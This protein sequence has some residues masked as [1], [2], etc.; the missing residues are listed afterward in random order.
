[1]SD[2]RP[3]FRITLSDTP[4]A[5]PDTHVL[6]RQRMGWIVLAGALLALLA[7][8]DYR[9]MA[10]DQARQAWFGEM[11]EWYSPDAPYPTANARRLQPVLQRASGD[12]RL[13]SGA[14][15]A[16]ALTEP[17]ESGSLPRQK[18][19]ER[20]DPTRLRDPRIEHL[21]RLR[22][23]W[24]DDP[25]LLA[26]TLR[27]YSQNHIRI[28]RD[29]LPA[30]NEHQPTRLAVPAVAR[31]VEQ[32]AA[33]GKRLDPENAFFPLLLAAA[34]FSA[35]E[36]EAGL[37]AFHEASRCPAWRNYG[38]EEG[39]AA[40]DLLRRG[41]GQIGLWGD[42]T[43]LA[44]VLLPEL[45]QIRRAAMMVTWHAE[46]ARV[47]GDFVR[48]H[49]LRADVIRAGV[50]MRWTG[51]TMIARLVGEAMVRIALPHSEPSIPPAAAHSEERSRN[52]RMMA[53]YDRYL[54]RVRRE[55]PGEVVQVA[56][57]LRM[58]RDQSA[59][60]EAEVGVAGW[61]SVLDPAR[62]REL[63]GLTLLLNLGVALL[64]WPAAALAAFVL[65]RFEPKERD[66]D[67]SFWRSLPSPARVAIL[68]M[69]GLL[70][71]LP[72][73]IDP[74]LPPLTTLTVEVL[75]L[76]VSWRI[77]GGRPVRWTAGQGALVAGLVV[78]A[79][80]AGTLPLLASAGSLE[81]FWPH[82]PATLLETLGSGD[83]RED[84]A[85]IV[86]GLPLL[87]ALVL[88]PLAA[89]VW[90]RSSFAGLAEVTRMGAKGACAALAVGYVLY[91]LW[92]VP[93][94][95]RACRAYEQVVRQ[96]A[97]GTLVPLGR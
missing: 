43:A 53:G 72:F 1:M 23:Q 7:L 55:R 42:A 15:L 29:E 73:L 3:R 91:L 20:W 80:A 24:P 63:A 52:E 33:A 90:R 54:E 37:R 47:H 86:I 93:A 82:T 6:V 58:L 11:P 14:I 12:A 50:A 75:V 69:T 26:H 4:A 51:D 68:L 97:A 81:A 36:D 28:Q 71:G 45:A 87:G 5:A 40:R 48:E 60:R 8:P 57:A 44:S 64:F 25:V 77:I 31:Q 74:M 88:V 17:F 67:A 41:Y 89:A 70:M 22:A 85:A 76:A 2:P 62:T 16:G 61:S 35:G 9:R 10:E 38:L 21:E 84:H 18:P 13:Q 66:A 79:A 78:L 30:G 96:E 27:Y 19:G 92:A 46:Q 49:S 83:Q 59:R 56:T 65:G 34:Y 95:V 94:D 32:Y 39:M